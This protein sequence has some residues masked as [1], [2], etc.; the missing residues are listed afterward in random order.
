MNHAESQRLS[1]AV[2]G[3]GGYTGLELISILL[4][5]PAVE[6]RGVFGSEK[7]DGAAPQAISS[8]FPAL[9]S[10]CD[11]PLM[12][13][14]AEAIRDLRPDVVFSCTPHQVS[15]DLAGALLG[16][17]GQAAAPGGSRG[18][19]VI[20]LSAAFR[21]KDGTLYPKHYGFE[22]RHAGLLR[23]AVFGIPELFRGQLAGA[24]LV[25]VAGCYPTSAILPIAPLVRAGAIE[26]GRR[27]IVDSVSGVSGA[28]RHATT[29]NLFCE[30]SLQPYNVF[31]HRHNPEIDAYAGTPVV[32]TPHLGCYDRGILST[33]H[34]DLAQGW[35]MQRVADALGSAYGD[36]PFIR[37]LPAGQWPS[38]AAVRHSN[39][40]D[41]AFAVDEANR[42]LIVVSA[43]DNLV[44]GASGQAVQ[45]MNARFGLP[46]TLGLLSRHEHAVVRGTGVRS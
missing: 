8:V 7:R 27:P 40:C 26:K 2:V 43:I 44:K 23:R 45:C 25:A 19:A 21:L 14:S 5:H 1:T 41:I 4:D 46:E 17:D 34:I 11:L 10:R 39:F 32:F 38:V 35:G 37:L 12:P 15:H 3:A 22:H 16:E 6:I 30:V 28:G 29:A 18:I 9:R 36:E 24:D 13:A 31:T 33:I 20:D 42:H